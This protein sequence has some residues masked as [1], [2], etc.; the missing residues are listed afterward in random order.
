M[1]KVANDATQLSN[2]MQ[3]AGF[4]SD[5]LAAVKEDVNPCDDFYEFACGTWNNE[6]KDKIDK[7]SVD[8]YAH[9]SSSNQSV[10]L[11]MCSSRPA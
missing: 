9:G 5:M 2:Q 11:F 3:L 10:M 8:Y 1:G 6:H 4:P 7:V